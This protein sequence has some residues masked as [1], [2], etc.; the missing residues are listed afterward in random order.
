MS[1]DEGPRDGEQ[2]DEIQDQ[3]SQSQSV[4]QKV[5][6]TEINLDS[7]DE[8]DPTQRMNGDDLRAS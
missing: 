7:S 1:G 3:Q 5:Q 2:E 8:E 4:K 6:T